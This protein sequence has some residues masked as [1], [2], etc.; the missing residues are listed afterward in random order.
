M[1]RQVMKCPKCQHQETVISTSPAAKN[2]PCPRCEGMV[3]MED[4][5]PLPNQSATA[6]S[7]AGSQA[8]KDTTAQ[9]KPA[10]AQEDRGMGPQPR[11][12]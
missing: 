1:S 11:G 10:P 6:W 12:G 8:I 9:D 2:P 3:R 7:T 4:I 5:T